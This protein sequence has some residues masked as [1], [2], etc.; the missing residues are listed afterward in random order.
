[1]KE[2]A[3]VKGWG[4]LGAHAIVHGKTPLETALVTLGT[5]VSGADRP[6]LSVINPTFDSF[7]FR[8]NDKGASINQTPVAFG[9]ISVNPAFPPVP[10]RTSM[11]RYPAPSDQDAAAAF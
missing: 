2:A 10:G 7:T 8:A 5:T 11:L 1:L 3:A 9:F 6:F 4:G